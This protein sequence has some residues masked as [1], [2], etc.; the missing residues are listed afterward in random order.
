[1]DVL[2]RRL[3]QTGIGC[4]INGCFVGALSYADDLA[5]LSPSLTGLQ[6][7]VKVCEEFGRDFDVTFNPKKSECIVFARKA[8]CKTDIYLDG[9]ALQWKN[10]VRHLGNYITHDLSEQNEIK[11]KTSDFIASVNYVRANFGSC[12]FDVLKFMFTTYCTS[13]YGCQSWDFKDR[14]VS[15]I[16]T[17]WNKAVRTLFKLP[18]KCRTKYL[19][20]L[21]DVPYISKQLQLRAHRMYNV[22]ERSNNQL[23]K[24]LYGTFSSDARSFCTT[25]RELLSNN[26]FEPTDQDIAIVQIVRDAFD[27]KYGSHFI[28][29][30]ENIDF[31][32]YADIVCCL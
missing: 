1:M 19:S 21:L 18:W 5:I 23:L 6:K 26:S 2:L 9:K 30:F 14:N 12:N 32:E 22:M 28:E 27:V 15:R 16:Y 8:P 4:H 17:C 3:E 13:F 11:R 10:C 31:C 20:M 29:N 7:L 25:N 24:T